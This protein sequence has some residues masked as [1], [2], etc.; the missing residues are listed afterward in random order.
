[1]FSIVLDISSHSS[2]VSYL[3]DVCFCK[4]IASGSLKGLISG[5]HYNRCKMI[6]PLFAAAM[7]LLHFKLFIS[8]CDNLGE[9]EDSSVHGADFAKVY[10]SN[11]LMEIID[12]YEKFKESTK[13]GLNGLTAQYWFI[14]IELI[15]IYYTFSRSTRS[16]NF[17]LYVY[18]LQMV[19][20]LFFCSNL[21]NYSRW[22]VRFHDNLLRIEETHPTLATELHKG[23]LGVKRTSTNFCRMPIDL[24]LEQTINADAASQRTGIAAFTNS[25]SARKCWAQN[26]FLRMRVVSHLLDT[27]DLNKKDVTAER[28]PC[29]MRKNA[30]ALKKLCNQI[31]E[32]INPYDKNLENNILVNIDTGKGASPETTDF[33][34]NVVEKE[35]AIKEVNERPSRFEDAITRNKLSTFASE[36]VKLKTKNNN[37]ISEVRMEGNLYGHLLCI[38]LVESIDISLV[39]TYPITPV[40]LSMCHIDGTMANTN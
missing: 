15:D 3:S 9:R 18:S 13:K 21:P 39:L 8:S 32:S 12:D 29:K 11:E 40:P 5:K 6:H 20:D 19:T 25:I 24:T 16:G 7:E 33:L 22:S 26:H 14:Y 28:K 4:V 35:S 38:V 27:L 37:K 36:G 2:L 23:R 1:M 17:E 31:E 34:L 10:L 30:D